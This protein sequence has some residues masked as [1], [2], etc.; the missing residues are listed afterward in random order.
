M[1][2][3]GMVIDDATKEDLWGVGVAANLAEHTKLSKFLGLNQLGQLHMTLRGIVSE[4]G[5][6]NSSC[7]YDVSSSNLISIT[8]VIL[9]L[10]N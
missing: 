4:C 7:D 2:T 10:P 8:T 6:Q 3:V 5:S 9:A 1:S